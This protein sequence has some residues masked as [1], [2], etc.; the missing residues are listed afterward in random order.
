MSSSTADTADRTWKGG[1]YRSSHDALLDAS[2]QRLITTFGGDPRIAADV[3]GQMVSAV[4]SGTG[5]VGG[6]HPAAST[7]AGMGQRLDAVVLLLD[8]ALVA[9]TEATESVDYLFAA[10][11]PETVPPEW[12]ASV[13]SLRIREDRDFVLPWNADSDE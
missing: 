8:S 11:M 13:A 6:R 1:G 4:S 10:P 5:T 3:L 9:D 2:L 7:T 12:I